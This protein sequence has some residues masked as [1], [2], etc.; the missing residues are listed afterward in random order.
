MSHATAMKPAFAGQETRL[1]L[2]PRFFF[3]GKFK[4]SGNAPWKC[5]VI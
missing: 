4:E 3:P 1:R 2:N 5:P